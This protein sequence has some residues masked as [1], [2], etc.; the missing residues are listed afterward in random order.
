MTSEAE[1]V[2]PLSR[3]LAL[4][5]LAV[6]QNSLVGGLVY[7]W[8]S[9]DHTLLVQEAKLDFD[10][11]TAIFSYATSIGMFSSLLMGPILDLYGP[12]KC[13][14]IAHIIGACVQCDIVVLLSVRLPHD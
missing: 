13:S 5:M 6:I 7:G 12:R 11:T 9:I 2:S 14:V 3:R 1:P 8:A 10:Q 4:A